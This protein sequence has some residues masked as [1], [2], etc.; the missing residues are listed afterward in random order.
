MKVSHQQLLKMYFGTLLLVLCCAIFWE[1]VGE[2]FWVNTFGGV[3]ESVTIRLEYIA[4][5]M[6]FTGFVLIIPTWVIGRA[7]RINQK[8]TD[9]VDQAHEA[10]HQKRNFITAITHDLRQPVQS[11]VLLHDVLAQ[12]EISPSQKQIVDHL[13]SS[14]AE[15]ALILDRMIEISKL[16]GDVLMPK[17]VPMTLSGLFDELRQEMTQKACLAGVDLRIVPSSCQII[18]DPSYLKRIAQQ[19]VSNAI[20]FAHSGRVLIG[21]R[22]YGDKIYF[23]VWDDGVGIARENQ[24][25]IFDDFVQI[26]AKVK[27]AEK[28]LGLGLAIVRRL[29]NA[30]GHKVRVFS[31][32]GHCTVFRIELPKH[33]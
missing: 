10:E 22:Q 16:D 17:A 29:C 1:F 4:T 19:L 28:G 5:V 31:V 30:L 32:P 8:L 33:H 27:P 23:E 2:V 25:R 13:Q 14:S 3:Q 7:L 15:I 18:S 12:E 9:A 26:D 21:C 20:K 6:V 24:E 11:L